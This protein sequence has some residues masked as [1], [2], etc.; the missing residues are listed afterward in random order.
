MR[1]LAC[2]C[3]SWSSRSAW[4]NL[5]RPD[6]GVASGRE[7]G[8][9]ASSERD[10]NLRADDHL[11]EVRVAEPVEHHVAR[12]RAVG[13]GTPELVGV[14]VLRAAVLVDL[15]ALTLVELVVP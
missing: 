7:P 10:Q 12:E 13:G 2:P 6:R 11:V 4:H 8:I 1:G 3:S 14:V 5:R 9:P 15:E